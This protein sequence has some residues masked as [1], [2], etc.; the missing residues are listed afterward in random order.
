MRNP[1]KA[2][3]VRLFRRTAL[4]VVVQGVI[5]GLVAMPVHAADASVAGDDDGKAV[6]LKAVTVTA[7]GEQD[8]ATAYTG[9]STR[10]AAGLPLTIKETPQSVNVFTQKRM[11]D[12][13]LATIN[14]VLGQSTGVSVREYDSARQYYFARGFEITNLLID[15]VPTLFD[16]GWGS[17]EN[18][19]NT[20][21]YEQIEVIRGATGLMTG[22]GNPSAAV[23]LVRKRATADSFGGSAT[24]VGG[25]RNKIGGTLDAGSALVASGAIRGR[26]VLSHEQQD[27]FRKIGASANSLFYATVEAD[28]TDSTLLTLGFSH[29]QVENDSPTWG[30]L[31]AWFDDGSRTDWDRSRTTAADWAYWDSRHDNAFVE[32]SQYL[33]DDWQLNARFNHGESDNE[34]RLLY[35]SGVTNR[36]TGL[37]LQGWPGGNFRFSSRYDTADVFVAGQ[38]ALWG[39][40]HDATLG[41][42]RSERTFRAHSHN[43]LQVAPIGDFNAWTG[44][45][46]PEHVWGPEFLY[47]D[48][49]DTQTALYASTRFF[50]TDKFKTVLGMRLTDQEIDRKAAAYNDAQVIKHDGIVTPY[51]G[52]LYD[53][54]DTYT[55][56]ASYT[57]IF[58]PQ[59]ERDVHGNSLDPVVGVSRELGLKAGYLDGR[60]TASVAVFSIRQDNLAQVDG[61]NMVPGTTESAYKESEGAT[62]KGYELELV[63]AVTDQWEVQLGWTQY[64]LED[65]D[66]EKINTEQPRR[67]LKTFTT[68]QMSGALNRLT[69]GG[70]INWESE[71][72]ASVTN[73]VTSAP[74]RI[75]QDALMLVNLMA[76]YQVAENL[77]AQLNAENLTDETFYTNLG[78]FGQIAYGEPRSVS[79]SLKLDF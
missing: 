16:P 5:A 62:S 7:S 6:Q 24:L 47:E 40:Q 29:Q 26:T 12:Q 33:N 58:K 52:V 74:E 27:S 14:E 73:P 43:A 42:S 63:G 69:L 60:L 61:T 51:L 56:Y 17:G 67:V 75:T 50:I 18:L 55:V 59:N 19:G 2:D 57:D 34:S 72:Y 13:G 66:K 21:L 38:F 70:G 68:Y 77:Q 36:D 39:R 8:P 30:G 4:S 22:S 76:R 32:L 15:G 78:T 64:E 1:V 53:L 37:G 31:P 44:R 45:G 46:Y 10:A 79:L 25:S 28:L 49:T 65:A 41:I 20:A 48:G 3:G 71:T 23:N 11:E 54:D 35:V 9:K